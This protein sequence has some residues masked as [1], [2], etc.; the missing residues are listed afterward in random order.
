MANFGNLN[1]D[2]K[3]VLI[4]QRKTLEKFSSLLEEVYDADIEQIELDEVMK[5]VEMSVNG[6]MLI[7]QKSVKN[8]LKSGILKKN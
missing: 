4:V 8:C 1:K 6:M 5:K 2:E 3:N 7:Y